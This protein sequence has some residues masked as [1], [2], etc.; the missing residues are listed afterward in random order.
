MIRRIIREQE[1]DK[2]PETPA[3]VETV[4]DSWAGGENLVHD[5]DHSEVT[6]GESNIATPE[7]L[8]IVVAETRRRIQEMQAHSRHGDIKQPRPGE[9]EFPAI[10]GYSINGQ[11][12]SEIV[13]DDE[14]LTQVL[15]Y[16]APLTG[17]GEQIP[18]SIDSLSDVEASDVPVGAEIERYSEAKDQN[19][20]GKNNFDDVKIARML[21]SGMSKEEIKKKYPDLFKEGIINKDKSM[22]DSKV[23]IT[24][25]QLRRIV[26]EAIMLESGIDANKR[27]M[28]MLSRDYDVVSDDTQYPYGR[29]RGDVRKKT[30]YA[31]K[32][33]QPVPEADINLL[34]DRDAKVRKD[35]GSMAALSGIYTSKVSD[36]GSQI[37]VDYYRHTAG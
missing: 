15:D 17:R 33:G 14:E 27:A 25:T 31:R 2:A 24:R 26:K 20:D 21:A 18:Y 28:E 3:D 4:E 19:K 32:D 11:E 34:K 5:L 9:T 16:L 22:G 37:V 7:T 1:E 36:D 30:V 13:Y 8:E 10:V 23:K 12:Q 35:G 29:Y 6:A